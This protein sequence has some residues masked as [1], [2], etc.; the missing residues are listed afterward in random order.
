MLKGSFLKSSK[1][2]KHNDNI[3][4]V[5]CRQKNKEYLLNKLKV[6]SSLTYSNVNGVLKKD[7]NTKINITIPKK[8]YQTH[9]SRSYINNT[10]ELLK[11]QN[12]WKKYK[13]YKHYFYN[14]KEQ[15]I[16]MKNH[17]SDIYD[18][19]KKCPIPVMK[20]DLW[21][22]CIIYKYG[23]I[24]ADADTV[25]LKK[26]DYLIKKSYL[27]GV[28]ENNTHLCQWIFSAPANSPILKSIIDLSVGRLREAKEFKGKHFIHRY[29]GPGVFTQG[30]EKWLFD[31]NYST[32]KEREKYSNYPNNIIFFY[33]STFHKY[34]V[35][36]LYS[37]KWENG[38][39]KQRTVFL[40][41][42]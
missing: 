30:I 8:I 2:V 10:P 13:D 16:F 25:C 24:Y 23:G 41:N 6:D 34:N 21:R 12:S 37:G 35:R 4:Y 31:N 17:F 38:W 9:K 19:Y 32:F 22:Y 36:H 15:D 20:A 39:L 28:P 1:I 14:N 42:K 11:A 3:Y 5:K 7:T 18:A 40:K 29:T 26:P 27:V 33:P